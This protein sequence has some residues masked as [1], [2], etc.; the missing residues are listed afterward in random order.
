MPGVWSYAC[1]HVITTLC[2]LAI[3]FGW[4]GLNCTVA[5]PNAHGAGCYKMGISSVDLK[6]LTTLNEM[7]NI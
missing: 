5:L 2:L 4:F 6:V 7:Q 3:A 1:T